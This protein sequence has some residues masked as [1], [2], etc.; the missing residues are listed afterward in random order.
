MVIFMVAKKMNDLAHTLKK[1]GLAASSSDAIRLASNVESTQKDNNEVHKKNFGDDLAIKS[2]PTQ[3]LGDNK[4]PNTLSKDQIV[5]ILQQFSDKFCAE[6]NSINAKLQDMQANMDAQ[7]V[8]VQ[9]APEPVAEQPA[10][11]PVAEQPAPEPVA[12]QP[13]PEP[14]AEQPAPAEEPEPTVNDM[15]QEPV[16]EEKPK[17]PQDD[18]MDSVDLVDTFNV[19]KK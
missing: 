10:P 7:P 18:M 12:E 3:D 16:E 4:M 11:E 9:P 2:S 13:A 8:A 15:V 17:N 1:H 19:N 5:D 6:I 14:V